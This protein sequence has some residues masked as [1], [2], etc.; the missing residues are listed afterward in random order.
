[1]LTFLFGRPGSGKTSYIINKIKEAVERGKRTYLLVPEQQAF[2]SESMLA[3]LPPSSAL[4]FEVI[5]FSRLCEIVFGKVGGLIDAGTGSDIRHLIMWQSIREVSPFLKEYKHVKIDR[6]FCSMMLAAVDELHSGG[7]TPEDCERMAEE[8]ED[9]ALSGKLSDIAAVYANLNRSIES[10]LGE[11]AVASEN[12]LTRLAEALRTHKCFAGC[13]VYVDSFT[14]FTGEE[15]AILEELALQ[16]DRLCVSFCYEGRGKQSPHTESIRET[17]KRFTRFAR[18]SGLPQED[19]VLEDNSRTNEQ[20]L[21]SLERLLWDF[22]VT[23]DTLP[24][25]DGSAADALVMAECKNEYEEAKFAALQILKAHAE[26]VKF[27]EMALIMRDCE[28]R[29]GIIDA[30]FEGMSIPYFYSDKTD[31][32]TTPVSRLILSALRCI[33]YHFKT[34]DVLTLLKTGLCGI[35][36]HD[37]DLFE[38]YCYTWSISGSRFLDDVWSMNPDGYTV[39]VSD[40]GKEILSAA[41]RVRREL[42]P[43]LTDLKLAFSEA[44]GDTVKNCRAIYDYLQRIGL[45]ESLSALAELELSAGNIKAAGEVLRIYD[46]LISALTDTCTILREAPTNAEELAA[47]IEIILSNSDIGSVP[48]INDYVTVGSASTL[49]VEN[50][51]VAILLGLCEGEFPKAYSETGLLSESDK[52]LMEEMGVSLASRE[53]RVMSDELFYVYRAM[54]KPSCRLVLCTCLSGINGRA[55]SPS[56]AWNRVRFLFPDVKPL[57]FDFERVAALSRSLSGDGETEACDTP[58]TEEETAV[59]DSKDAREEEIDPFYVR[60][61]FG[62]KLRLSKSQ[63]S[64]FAECPY[65]YWCEYVLRLREQK[66]SAVSYA[67]SGTIIHYVLEKFLARIRRADGSLENVNDEETVALVNEIL[68]QYIS[69]IM[70]PLPPSMMHSFSRIRD[71]SLIMVRSVLEEFRQSD[72]RILAFEKR[73]SD[74]HE[75]ALAPMEIPVSEENGSPVVSLGGVI[76]RVDC[77]DDGNRAFLRIVDYKT[78]THKFDVT[79]VE[80][81]EDLQLPAYLFTAALAQ[82]RTAFGMDKELFP[83]SALFL[84]AEE[85]KG[86]VNPVRS[87]FILR[88]QELL[89]AASAGMDKKILAGISIN[90]D[91]EITGKA[92]VSEER[93]G[94]IND[95]LQRS[96]SETARCMYSGKAPRTSSKEACA[97]CSV[98]SS[99]PVASR[100]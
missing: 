64:T 42:I 29:K 26:G 56:S 67:D 50:V 72:F 75:G 55:L 3:D 41:N 91:G 8:C 80:T 96:I 27:S 79:K 60:M 10:L 33:T 65:R 2:I 74:R 92:A 78:G 6:A 18:E 15:H 28:S 84:S 43:P 48:A 23:K 1:M 36:P 97:F 68:E 81:G 46:R 87:G 24:K 7:I 35:D 22:S 94:M 86:E 51:K 21:L 34:S 49:R 37:A 76:D 14:S 4:C 63:I 47:A 25:I 17:V 73:I 44:A 98:R 62:D 88:D 31:L 38:D 71:L 13:D 93:I 53:S 95:S 54:T 52:S 59:S 82:N 61:L 20:A 77:Y 40:R 66:I 30:V 83:A 5:T 100:E 45:S 89:H 99:C 90:K 12:K 32:S 19:I 58:L 57:K 85:Q 11:S 16:A 70:C 9:S 69:R 39:E